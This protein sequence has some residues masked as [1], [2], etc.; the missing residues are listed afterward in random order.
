MAAAQNCPVT[1]TP[2]TG[3]PP[4]GKVRSDLSRIKAHSGIS[5]TASMDWVISELI[6][7]CELVI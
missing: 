2:D 3:L 7:S 4:E 6:I 1:L 5:S